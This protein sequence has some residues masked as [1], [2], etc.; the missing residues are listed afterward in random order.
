AV[1]AV[2]AGHD[3]LA[4]DAVADLDAM[5]RKRLGRPGDDFADQLVTG[6]DAG[7]DPALPGLVA[8]ELGGPVVALQ[9]A[10]ARADGLAPPQTL[11]GCGGGDIDLLEAVVLGCMHD[12]CI[13]GLRDLG[14]L[15]SSPSIGSRPCPACALARNSVRSRT[16]T[17]LSWT[18]L[19]S[20]RTFVKHKCSGRGRGRSR[21]RPAPDHRLRMKG[22]AATEHPKRP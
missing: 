5:V 6:R 12:D 13:H 7:L 11:I 16:T 19:R 1:Q 21:S 15:G 3:L 20:R 17:T 2:A 22:P 14:H 8:P 10:R 4:G 9:V 18:S